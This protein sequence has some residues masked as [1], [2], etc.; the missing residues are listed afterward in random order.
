MKYNVESN[1]LT[2]IM[3]GE[4]NS[5]NSEDVEK[6]IDG[7]LSQNDVRSII[8]DMGDLRYISSA[9]LRIIVRLKQNYD[10][11]RLIRVPENIYSI[12]SMVGFQNIISIERL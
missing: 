6:E 3:E 11:T 8:V 7:V 5:F 9:G 4:L 12:F 2:I 1:I 10:D